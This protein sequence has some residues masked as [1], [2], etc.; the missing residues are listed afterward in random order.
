MTGI[1]MA[2]WGGITL[3]PAAIAG[4]VSW[5]LVKGKMLNLIDHE[6]HRE[7]CHKKSV[8]VYAKFDKFVEQQG[9]ILRAIGRIEGKLNGQSRG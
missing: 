9:E 2:F 1:E 4:G 7:I 6:T 8:E 3:V 5:G